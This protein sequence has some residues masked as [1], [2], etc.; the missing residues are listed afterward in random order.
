MP[1]I[2]EEMILPS[3]EI[4]ASGEIDPDKL[5]AEK[6]KNLKAINKELEKAAKNAEI[7]EAIIL[8]RKLVLDED[9]EIVEPE[10]QTKDVSDEAF[11]DSSLVNTLIKNKWDSIELFNSILLSFRQANNNDAEQILSDII[12]D[13]YVHVGQLEKLAQL[14]NPLADRIDDGQRETD[15][16]VGAD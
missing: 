13:E 16:Q 7:K 9:T 1:N 15:S 3:L 10:T 2:S 8:G 5:K 11:M 4:D 6:E 12:N 14:I